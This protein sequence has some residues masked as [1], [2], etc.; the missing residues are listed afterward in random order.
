VSVTAGGM[1]VTTSGFT[2]AS[3]GAS[4]GFLETSTLAVTS[5]AV[6]LTLASSTAA[7]LDVY[8]SSATFSGNLLYGSVQS[9]APNPNAML[10]AVGS[11]PLVKV[12]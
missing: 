10:L 8:D 6:S 11:T 5:G 1:T 7:T 4:G 9:G 2:V 3:G 12:G